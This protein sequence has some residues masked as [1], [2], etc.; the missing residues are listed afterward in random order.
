MQVFRV[1]LSSTFRDMVKERRRLQLVFA[2]LR[3][4]A[5][6]ADIDFEV[7]DLRWGL[8]DDTARNGL[9]LNTCLREVARAKPLFIALLGERYGWQ[10]SRADLGLLNARTDAWL[11]EGLSATEMEIRSAQPLENRVF[12]LRD[13]ALTQIFAAEENACEFFDESSA[14]SKLVALKQLLP[15]EQCN[16][17]H[18]LEELA[19]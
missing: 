6:A 13:R 2:N 4:L 19:D 7:I 10:P 11:K 17:Y 8:D 5:S 1:F 12:F 16:H 9:V 15:H 14:A 3:Q 18:S